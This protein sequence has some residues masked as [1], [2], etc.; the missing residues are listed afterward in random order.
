MELEKLALA[1]CKAREKSYAPYSGFTVGAALLCGD[2]S[3]YSGCNIEN[4]AYGPTICAER[5]AVF[6]AV[7]DGKRDFVGLALAGGRADRQSEHFLTPCGVGRQ[8]LTEFC[9]DDF[10]VLSVKNDADY[11]RYTL[12]DLLPASFRPEHMSSKVKEGGKP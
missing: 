6:K 9:R 2:G 4:A 12:G 1:A 8:V 10:W 11:I 7:S 5:T 3:V